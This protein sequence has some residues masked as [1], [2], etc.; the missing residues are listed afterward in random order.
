MQILK[1]SDFTSGIVFLHGPSGSGK[2]VVQDRLFQKCKA[3][4]I[5]MFS[6]SSGDLFRKASQTKEGASLGTKMQVGTYI[7]TLDMIM[8]QLSEVFKNHIR[9][10]ANNEQSILVL[11]GVLRMGAYQNKDSVDI[12]SQIS[13][14]GEALTRALRDFVNSETPEK[15]ISMPLLMK[16]FRHKD[17]PCLD[18][19][20]SQDLSITRQMVSDAKHCLINVPQGDAEALMRLRSRKAMIA[21]SDEIHK[22]G[23]GEKAWSISDFLYHA[24][25]IQSGEFCLDG[26]RVFYQN[27]VD[28]LA[29]FDEN[30]GREADA[31][32]KQL[33]TDFCASQKIPVPE[34]PSIKSVTIDSLKKFGMELSAEVELPRPDDDLYSSRQSRLGSFVEKTIPMLSDPELGILNPRESDKISLVENGP[35]LGITYEV[36]QKNAD[37]VAEKLIVWTRSS[38]EHEHGGSREIK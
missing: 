11:D 23:I 17:I 9:A 7:E 3:L 22:A 33:I 14:V 31:A 32:M 2:T 10:V 16:A 29:P 18:L 35:S 21:V 24:C 26:G 19:N 15:M 5:N 25:Q 6:A 30:K 36:L 12:P 8:P 27:A 1:L 20:M 37:I 38:Q 4:G 13:Q 34:K 28:P